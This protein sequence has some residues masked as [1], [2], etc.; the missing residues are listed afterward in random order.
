MVDP[1]DAA[2]RA[3]LS[4]MLAQQTA[5]LDQVQAKAQPLATQQ[6]PQPPIEVGPQRVNTGLSG[7]APEDLDTAPGTNLDISV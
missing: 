7:Q 2:P 5:A 1:V 6:S 4:L 3:N